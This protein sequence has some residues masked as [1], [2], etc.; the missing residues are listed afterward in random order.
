MSSRGD[1]LRTR[2]M[3][4]NSRILVILDDVWEALHDLD[5]LGIPS[6]SNHNYRCKVILTMR[7]RPV[8]E[9][10]GAQRIM[11]KIGNS[12]DDFS[13]LDIA[14]NV[15]KEC[16]GLPL[17]II[18][19]A[20]ALKRKAKPFWKDAL[21]QLR[22]VETRNIPGVHTKVY[23]PLRLS[24]DYLE[25]EDSDILIEELLKYGMGLRI[26]SGIENLE[27]ARNRVYLLLELLK[28]GFL[29]SQ[30]SD[31][32]HVKMHDVVRDVA[33]SIA[34]EGEHNFMVSYYVNSKEF[35]RKDSYEQYSHMPIVANKFDEFRSPIV[36]PKLK[37]LMLKLCSG[38]PFK[39]QDDFF[40]GMSNLNVIS[41]NSILCLP[42]SIRRLSSLRT[43]CLSNLRLGDISIIGELVTLEIL[44]IRECQLEEVPVKIGKLTNLIM[45]SAG[46]LSRLV[47]LEEL[48]MVGVKHCSY[49]IL[50]EV[51][52]LSRLTALTLSECSEDVMYIPSNLD[53]SSKFARYTLAVSEGTCTSGPIIH[54]YDKNIVL[55]ITKTTP[56]EREMSPTL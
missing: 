55:V 27:D 50:S 13:L 47:R 5:K 24:Y 35:P 23:K 45:I 4:Q 29:L 17:A 32:S 38:K 11:E 52:S 15:S 2:L 22:D 36:C 54:D 12:V 14:K 34:S 48:H 46:V 49:S 31:K 3:D 56:L 26:F 30:G 53:L 1:L 20:G 21:K 6:G 41:L 18:T 44:N 25:K 8:C 33:I 7:L 16:K 40:D 19:V 28:D 10:M 37:F 51:E 39:L 43:L 9:A 42:A